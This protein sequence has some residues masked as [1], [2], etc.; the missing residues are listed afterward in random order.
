MTGFLKMFV[1]S[2]PG[3]PRLVPRPVP[4]FPAGPDRLDWGYWESVWH[5]EHHP[6]IAQANAVLV[7]E[8]VRVALESRFPDCFWFYQ[9]TFLSK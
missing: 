5:I 3:E 9:E 6:D 8:R 2:T 1:G 4:P 7:S